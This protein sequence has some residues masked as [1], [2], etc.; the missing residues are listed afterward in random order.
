[1]KFKT[2]KNIIHLLILAHLFCLF[3]F[4]CSGY[5]GKYGSD[6]YSD[7]R[8]VSAMAAPDSVTV[9]KLHAVNL[10]VTGTSVFLGAVT[11]QG[12]RIIADTAATLHVNR[13]YVDSMDSWNAASIYVMKTIG[14]SYTNNGHSGAKDTINWNSSCK[15]LDTLTA[16]CSL[17]FTAPTAGA[18]GLTLVLIQ[19]GTGSYTVTW[20]STVLWPDSSAP[21]LSTAVGG[22]D[23][24]S[25]FY[26]SLGGKYHGVATTNFK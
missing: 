20:P 9:K 13:E 17:S 2:K 21:T 14:F 11:C 3:I 23:I 19:G 8:A 4:P 5:C 25:L 15:Q 16:A 12:L 22:R 26:S 7:D 1:M 10:A 18:A 24:I 6:G